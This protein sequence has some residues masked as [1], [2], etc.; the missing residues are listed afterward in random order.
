VV[1]Y[2]DGG[3]DPNP[4]V[5][6]WAAI[7]L[8]GGSEKILTGND[9]HTTNNRM[10]LTAAVAALEALKRPCQVEFFTDS[11]YVRLGISQW[12][13]RWEAKKWQLSARRPVA[14]AD[15]WQKLRQLSRQ[16][17]IEWRWVRGHAGNRLNERV[18]VLARQA[19]EAITAREKRD[20]TLTRLYLRAS[21]RGNPGPGGWGV[22]IERG[23]ETEQLSGSSAETTNNREEIVA[24]LEG[25]SHLAPGEAAQLV[26][27]SD[28]LYQGATQWLRGWR[29]RDWQK[30]DGTP[31]AHGDLWRRLAAAMD[32]RPVRW[33]SVKSL[34]DDERQGLEE[35][36]RLAEAAARLER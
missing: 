11:E 36:A 20:V 1:I 26:T 14:N 18:D 33:L 2:S 22:V 7:L 28:Y 29:Q 21:V 4:G 16:H 3:A 23:G 31:V 17:S 32:E 13:E 27:V 8:S 9:P 12:I 34:A 6:G 30:K 35:A 5:G 19:R 25:L 15:L 10:E 24:A